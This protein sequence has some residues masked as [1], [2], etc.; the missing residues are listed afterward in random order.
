M[1]VRRSS[2]ITQRGRL[3]FP[4]FIYFATLGGKRPSDDAWDDVWSDATGHEPSINRGKPGPGGIHPHHLPQNPNCAENRPS[5]ARSAIGGCPVPCSVRLILHSDFRF[6]ST[7]TPPP[8][9]ARGLAPRV[10]LHPRRG[11]LQRHDPPAAGT[12]A[13]G[14]APTSRQRRFGPDL[15]GNGDLSKIEPFTLRQ[16]SKRLL[17]PGTRLDRRSGDHIILSKLIRVRALVSTR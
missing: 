6:A 7:R 14:C 2:A 12:P 8:A 9:D 13:R 5:K 4:A 17:R 11:A 16:P 3:N 1:A 15:N 10:K